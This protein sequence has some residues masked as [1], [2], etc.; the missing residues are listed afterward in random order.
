MSRQSVGELFDDLHITGIEVLPG[1]YLILLV[2]KNPN[3]GIM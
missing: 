1:G 2:F 3:N